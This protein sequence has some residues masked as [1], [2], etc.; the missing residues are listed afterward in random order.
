M[1]LRFDTV[2]QDE[3]L[4]S[5]GSSGRT[6]TTTWTL[7]PDISVVA[8]MTVGPTQHSLQYISETTSQENK[9]GKITFLSTLT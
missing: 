4:S 8:N 7:E 9:A 5:E 6:R 2:T 3:V 1:E